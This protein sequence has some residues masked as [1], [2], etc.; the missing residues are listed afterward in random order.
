M[1]I[2]NGIRDAVEQ[3]LASGVDIN[4]CDEK[5]KTP[6]ILASAKAHLDLCIFLLEKGANP[7]H[8]DAEGKNALHF[9]I[10]NGN[11]GLVALLLQ[12]KKHMTTSLTLPV[13]EEESLQASYNTKI[14]Y[15]IILNETNLNPI[16][17]ESILSSWEEELETTA[18]NSDFGCFLEAKKIQQESLQHKVVDND[19][20]WLDVDIELPEIHSYG[21]KLYIDDK[22]KWIPAVRKLFRAGLKDL[23]LCEEQINEIIPHDEWGEEIDPNFKIKLQIAIEDFGIYIDEKIALPGLPEDNDEDEEVNGKDGDED[24]DEN[25]D[26]KIKYFKDLMVENNDP[27]DLY[28]NEI[29]TGDLLSQKEEVKIGKEIS[30][31]MKAI[32]GAIIENKPALKEL[33]SIL[34]KSTEDKSTLKKFAF[35]EGEK[36]KNIN[37]D[38][39][40]NVWNTKN[41]NG[42]QQNKVKKLLEK[43]PKLYAPQSKY[44]GLVDKIHQLNLNENLIIHLKKIIIENSND[45]ATY[46][47]TE[48]NFQKIR[49]G[50]IQLVESNLRLVPW[51]ARKYKGLPY[52][53]L[54]QE[55][56]LGLIK[57]AERFDYQRGVK[58][59]T[60]AVWW[61]RQSITRAISNHSRFIRI[62]SHLNDNCRRIKKSIEKSIVSTGQAPTNQI[63]ASELLAS[64]ETVKKLVEIQDEPICIDEITNFDLLPV[65]GKLSQNT[66]H[67]SEIVNQTDIQESVS[68]ALNTLKAREAK[69]ISMRFG[70][71]KYNEHSLREVG[72]K[73]GLSR[74]RIR[75]IERNSLIKLQRS[76]LIQSLN[77]NNQE[78]L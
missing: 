45:Q 12:Y 54:I 16:T 26:R 14:S 24:D 4:A 15:D 27:S 2:I 20:D 63:L 44:T 78:Y 59:S 46:R 23:V 64:V 3:Q 69:I 67:F 66:F 17:D 55:G 9:A 41:K 56:N 6:L 33:I 71:G 1:S 57:A 25:L 32:I 34:E 8:K 18:P 37:D 36:T 73:M 43:F 42:L 70:I 50:R 47:L 53:D 52:L 38:S 60:Y 62:P 76:G 72:V 77:P 49:E 30:D 35:Y 13:N 39:H 22:A 51:V 29:K 5:G 11:Q 31:G 21:R 58:F 40:P 48:Y 61:I 75:Q 7:D 19:E 65:E 74:E 28:F 68:K 10:Q